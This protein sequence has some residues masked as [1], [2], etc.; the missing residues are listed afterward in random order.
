MPD[1]AANLFPGSKLQVR[2]AG[3]QALPGGE[4]SECAKAHRKSNILYQARGS[5]N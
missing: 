5:T 2:Q 3:A 1:P 4:V